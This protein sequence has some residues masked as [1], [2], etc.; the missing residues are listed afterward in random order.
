MRHIAFF[1]F[2]LGATST[3][4]QDAFADGNQKYVEEHYKTAIKSYESLIDSVTR[5]SEVF[6]NLGNAYYKT[7]QIGK[8]IW[9]YESALKIDPKNEDAKFNLEFA[10]LQ[11]ADKI[12]QPKPAL[13][14]WLKRLL[15][16]PQINLWAFISVGCS[17]ALSLMILLFFMTKSR[18][19]LNISLMGG[20]TFALLLIFS[21]IAAYFHKSSILQHSEGII[22]SEVVNVRL[23]PLEKANVTFELHEGAKVNLQD[24]NEE[25]LQ[26]EVGGNSGWVLKEEVWEI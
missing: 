18:R 1:L 14:E 10:N 23:S 22:I 3:F 6:Y 16:G 26:I 9:A 25:W 19:Q 17:F 12:E 13:T 5:S 21:T 2:L 20:M 15:F 24:E 7:E 11:T 8:A 4:G